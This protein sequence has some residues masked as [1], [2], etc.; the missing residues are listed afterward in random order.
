[1]PI[2]QRDT[3]QHRDVAVA[4]RRGTLQ[5]IAAQRQSADARDDRTRTRGQLFGNAAR[6]AARVLDRL[7]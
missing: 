7:L 3:A 6:L 5:K 4:W 1:M 2:K